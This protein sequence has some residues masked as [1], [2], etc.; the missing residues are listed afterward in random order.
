MTNSIKFKFLLAL[1]ALATMGIAPPASAI[2]LLD[3]PAVQSGIATRA[4]LLDV[5]PRGENGFVAVGEHGVILGSEDGGES[6]TQANVPA[7]VT[8]TG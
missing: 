6:W 1:L 7:S 5:T 4:L 8:L 2:D 3:L